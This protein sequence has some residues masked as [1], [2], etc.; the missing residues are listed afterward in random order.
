MDLYA[1][2][3]SLPN[4]ATRLISPM[5]TGSGTFWIRR[6][7]G[8]GVLNHD[9]FGAGTPRAEPARPAELVA[10]ERAAPRGTTPERSARDVDVAKNQTRLPRPLVSRVEPH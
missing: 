5:C 7:S 3:F 8:A 6:E 2:L 9:V 10:S 1:R 4:R